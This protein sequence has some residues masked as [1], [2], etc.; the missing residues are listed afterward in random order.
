MTLALPYTRAILRNPN[1]LFWG[2]AFMGFWFV[3][4]AFV[5]SVGLPA[6][7][8]AEVPYT[9]AWFA[10]IA[11]FSLTVIAM[12]LATSMTYGTDALA[13][14]FR[15]TRLRPIG[16]ALSLLVA[17]AAVGLVFTLIMAVLV[18]GLFSAH[19]G[20]LILPANLPALVGVSL[21]AGAFMM[22]L[23][24]ALVI[25][26][27]NYL[28]LRSMNFVEF[29]PL[30]LSYLFGFAQLYLAL[31]AIVL[32]VSPWNDMESLLY[33]AFRGAP[34]TVALTNTSSAA[35]SW[36]LSVAGLAGWVV[37]LLVV[38][39]GLLRR[40]RSVSLQEGRQV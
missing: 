16:Y 19:F 7:R 26:V 9:A 23:A 15:F 24:T 17:A 18:S 33:Q 10:V 20:T 21:L 11:L 3:L 25:V 40:I 38:S 13:F 2:V 36:P 35:L 4:G 30:V 22:T 29:L 14:G 27:V 5:F 39:S 32:Y 1:L 37:V 12:S 6:D 28:G 8:A 31:P 34:A